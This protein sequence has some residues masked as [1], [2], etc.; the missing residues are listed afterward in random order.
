MLGLSD[1]PMKSE[2][3]KFYI[4]GRLHQENGC[5]TLYIDPCHMMNKYAL[6]PLESD[7]RNWS[8]SRHHRNGTHERPD[9]QNE[10]RI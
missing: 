5:H 3:R 2:M 1:A 7:F 8:I 4:S 9:P 10:I 6:L